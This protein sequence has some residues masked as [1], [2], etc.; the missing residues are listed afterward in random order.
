MRKFLAQRVD[1]R[2]AQIDPIGLLEPIS[3]I[4]PAEAEEH[5]YATLDRPAMAA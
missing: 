2:L 3:N 1:L 4:Q 5:Y